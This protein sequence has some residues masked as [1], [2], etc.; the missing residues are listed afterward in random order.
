MRLGDALKSIVFGGRFLMALTDYITLGN[1]GLRVSPF[2]LGTMTFGTQWGWGASPET[3]RSIL[4]TYLEHGGNFIDTANIYTKGFSE[5]LI[6]EFFEEKSQVAS[7]PPRDR[8]IIATKFMG[9]MYPGDPNGGGANRKSIIQACE[10]S[11]RRLRT[12]YIDLYYAHFWDRH[13]PI[14]EWVRALEDLVTS[15]KVR[16]LGLSDHPA[17]VCAHAQGITKELGKSPFIA[18]QI[19]YSLLQRS[20]EAEL[21]PM[22]QALGLGVTPWSPLRGGLLSGKYT[23]E[24]I[25]PE[26][27][28]RIKRESPHLSERNFEI[29]DCVSE[30]AEELGTEV[31]PAQ[32]AL[33]WVQSQSG[34]TSTIIGAKSVEQ[35]EENLKALSLSL[36]QEYLKRLETVSA[37]THPFPYD[38]L[39]N[40]ERIIG[41]GTSTN[42]VATEQWDLAPTR[43]EERY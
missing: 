12:D 11:L 2:C 35:L 40:A 8:V 30:I 37:V 20:V 41:G 1:S 4:H 18:L 26:G 38:F 9:N 7:N 43:D 17:W 39:R 21:I 23:R 27:T 29:V 28:V 3:S 42:G 16:Y 19:E 14:E 22:A 15:G 32:V 24:A 6:G 33:S 5:H 36:G 34:V 10:Q 25:P 31:T 13:T